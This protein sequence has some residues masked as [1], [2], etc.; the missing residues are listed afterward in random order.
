MVIGVHNALIPHL[1]EH[2]NLLGYVACYHRMHDVPGIW[3]S[4]TL[5]T[6]VEVWMFKLLMTSIQGCH[7]SGN[8]MKKLKQ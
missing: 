4:W 1:H 5:H 2:N 3:L 6:C 7:C 8:E